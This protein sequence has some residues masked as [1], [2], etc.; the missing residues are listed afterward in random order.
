MGIGP[1]SFYMQ[2]P[3]KIL[4]SYI[5]LTLALYFIRKY[6]I[7]IKKK[8][9]DLCTMNRNHCLVSVVTC[10]N[11]VQYHTPLGEPYERNQEKKH[12]RNYRKEKNP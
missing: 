8:L 4:I 10:Q 5:S 3:Q 6:F 2:N 7:I 12:E 1:S 11:F 9:V